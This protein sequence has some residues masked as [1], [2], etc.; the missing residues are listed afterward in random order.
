MIRFLR[1]CLL[2]FALL[3]GAAGAQ[4]YPVKAV[5][6]IVP[7]PPGG[8]MD[9]LGRIVSQKLQE[10][11]EQAVVV[12]NRGGATGNIGAEALARSAADGYT[13]GIAGTPHAINMSLSPELRY[14]LAKDLAP[15]GAVAAF[16]SLIAV[17]PSLP[18]RSVKDL[19]ALA[20]S[21]PDALNF[22]S[23]GTGSPN[24]LA[25]E[26]LKVMAGIRM[27]HVPY[28]GSGPLVTDLLAG[29][30]QLASMGLPPSLQYVRAGRLR[31]IAVTS[32]ERSPLLPELPTVAEAGL[33]GFEVTSW[34]GIF[35]PRGIAPAIAGR[36]N[37]D[38]NRLLAA[39]D[40]R[41]RLLTLGAGAL[42]MSPE[43]FGRHVQAE[44]AKWARAVADSGVKPGS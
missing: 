24:H 28:K 21:R 6:M 15:L 5:R 7:S 14:H 11:W 8:A 35:S 20:K 17:H 10:Q 41:E 1:L 13:L 4:G 34:Y 23:A 36:V 29:H 42:P 3:A 16:P 27:V 18:V 19:V 2:W 44:I 32:R 12:D 40:V 33:A 25:I 22:G 37:A 43:E 30:V 9:L 31:A 38:L 26:I 39:P